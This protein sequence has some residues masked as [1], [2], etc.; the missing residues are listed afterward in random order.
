MKEFKNWV[1]EHSNV[2]RLGR[3]LV[4]WKRSDLR[5]RQ[6]LRVLCPRNYGKKIHQG[7]GSNL[8]CHLLLID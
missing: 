1:M 5:G 6:K 8:L 7:G 2:K 3:M 4:T